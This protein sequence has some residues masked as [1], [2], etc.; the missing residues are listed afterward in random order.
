M[1]IKPRDIRE[2]YYWKFEAENI[3]TVNVGGI[4]V[5][6]KVPELEV[7]TSFTCYHNYGGYYGFFRPS[8]DEVL[9]QI[10]PS[11]DLDQVQG[12]EIKI[13]SLNLSDIFDPILDR[14]VT[15]V[16]LYKMK[17]GLPSEIESQEVIY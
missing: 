11:V 1:F 10:P 12:F 15:T 7:V 5:P 9:S 17:G 8:V 14:H 2:G 13:D 3:V 6:L 4:E 16:I